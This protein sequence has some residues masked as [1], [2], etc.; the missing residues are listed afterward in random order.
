MASARCG[1]RLR[2]SSSTND[3][4]GRLRHANPRGIA[5]AP[6]RAQP[7]SRSLPEPPKHK[8]AHVDLRSMFLVIVVEGDGA[9]RL[10]D[11]IARD[12]LD[13]PTTAAEMPD[14]DPIDRLAVPVLHIEPRPARWQEGGHPKAM[15]L[16]P[17]PEKRFRDQAVHPTRGSGVP[18]PTAAA[19]VLRVGVDVRRH[20]VR[21]DLVPRDRGCLVAMMQRVQEPE[22]LPRPFRVAHGGESHD[23]PNGSVRVLTAIFTDARY[24]SLHV[25]RVCR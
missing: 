21:L 7:G 3:A 23:R 12:A 8:L 18:G 22:E 2:R 5:F 9:L 17:E 4:Q 20:D 24:V 15:H 11:A 19:R 10:L 14:V 13:R 1:L 25:T 6:S 16:E